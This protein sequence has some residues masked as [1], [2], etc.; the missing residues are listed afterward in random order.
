MTDKGCPFC[1]SAKALFENDLAVAI[2]DKYPVRE[3]HTL[4]MPRRHVSSFFELTDEEVVACYELIKKTK[5]M[6]DGKYSP[7]GYKLGIN[8]GRASGQTVMHAH[9]HVVPAD[10]K[11]ISG[12]NEVFSRKDS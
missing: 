7:G 9:I 12:R 6:L 2:P 1:S 3:G 11:R 8:I 10:G 5:E 4:V